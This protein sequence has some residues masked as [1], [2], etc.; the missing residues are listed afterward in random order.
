M[1]DSLNSLI[2]G[3]YLRATTVDLR[4]E[5]GQALT[6]YALVLALIVVGAIVAMKTI[7]DTIVGKFQ[8]VC[9][10]LTGTTNNPSCR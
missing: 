3:T 2:I 1:L 4:R 6:E 7:G 10:K 8:T 5:E 9:D